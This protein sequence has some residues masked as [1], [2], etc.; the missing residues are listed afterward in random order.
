MMQIEERENKSIFIKIRYLMLLLSEGLYRIRFIVA[1]ST[2]AGDGQRRFMVR[3]MNIGRLRK[4]IEV[5]QIDLV[6]LMVC[7]G[8]IT[9]Y[10]CKARK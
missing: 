10:S 1:K 9:R 6:K 8:N 2:M 7:H 5:F 3:E 4:T